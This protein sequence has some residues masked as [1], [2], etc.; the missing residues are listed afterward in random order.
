M[1]DKIRNAFPE[2]ING[3]CMSTV[4]HTNFKIFDRT[5]NCCYV[6]TENEPKSL[7]HFQVNNPTQKDIHFL[8][9]DKCCI[10]SDDKKCDCALFDDVKFHFV[11]IMELIFHIGS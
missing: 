8:A 5:N 2:C 6:C 10:V 11:E 7:A 3:D 4:N 9:I 1:R